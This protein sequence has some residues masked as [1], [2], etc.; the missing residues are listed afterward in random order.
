MIRET[1][2]DKLLTTRADG[3]WILSMCMRVPADL[4]HLRGLPARA[5]E[6]L[7][8]AASGMEGQRQ[9]RPREWQWERRAVHR[10]LEVH[11]RQ[12][13]G[14]TV[15]MFACDQ[16]GLAQAFPLPYGLGDRA[17]LAARPHVRP[18]LV[19]LQRCPSYHVAVVNRRHAWIFRITGTQIDVIALPAAAGVPSH[20]YGGWYGLESHRVSARVTE[21]ARHHWRE[22]AAALLRT[23]PGGGSSPLVAGGHQETISSFLAELPGEVRERFIGSFLVD[24]H[25][26]TAA[27]VRELS[28]PLVREWVGAREQDMVAQVLA[29][30]PSGRGGIGLNSCLAAV[31]SGAVAALIV[32]VGGLIPGM[33]CDQCGML[34]SVPDACPHK[35]PAVHPVPDLL[36]EMAVATR[37]EGG[38]VIAVDDPP[39]DAA[40]LLRFPLPQPPGQ[41]LSVG[42]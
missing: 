29:G 25:S 12:W 42:R 6:L 3:P 27:R 2:V 18:L 7:R 8:Q 40:A 38:E 16:I 39:A 14:N 37:N 13:L 32:P 22:T 9:A 34:S 30:V 35:W 21:L 11:A 23:L 4:P 24:P 28:A 31:N 36:E 33:A 20:R 5:D 26:I 41:R 15:A 10:M 17:V 19:A 1:D